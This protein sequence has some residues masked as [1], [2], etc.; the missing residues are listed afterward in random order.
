MKITSLHIK[1][2]HRHYDYDVEFNRDVTFLYGTN[3]CGKTTILNITEAIVSGQLYKMFD[4]DFEEIILN[5]ISDNH[6][7]RQYGISIRMVEKNM[8]I[9]FNQKQYFLNKEDYNRIVEMSDTD[10][11]IYEEFSSRFRFLSDIYKTFNYVYLPL[12]RNVNGGFE[13]Y[14]NRYSRAYLRQRINRIERNRILGGGNMAMDQVEMMIQYKY[15]QALAQVSRINDDFRNQILTSLLET[16][17][18]DYSSEDIFSFFKNPM[19]VNDVRNT[20][21]KYIK[22]LKSLD[23]I[24]E[25]D[26]KKYTDFFEGYCNELETIDDNTSRISMNMIFK[27]QELQRIKTLLPIAE[28]TEIRKANAMKPFKQFID[29][30]NDFVTSVDSDKRFNISRTGS[31]Y[32]TTVQSSEKIDISYLSSGEKQLLIF[33]SNLIFGVNKN[34][35]GI[36]IVDEPELSLHLAWQKR[37]VDSALSIN[38]NMQL[39]FATHSPEIIG[40]YRNKMFHLEKKTNA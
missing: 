1:K 27:M 16:N 31:V 32:F 39:I 10:E 15:Q 11:E 13:E 4:Y 35:T 14:K 8:D 36:F 2:L 17:V 33:F 34:S 7:D 26:L 3:G 21:E 25:G 12:N 23:L 18:H 30:M 24:K 38:G 22:L 29:I 28:R 5:Y 20:Q 37:F 6:L 19:T 9:T 40:K